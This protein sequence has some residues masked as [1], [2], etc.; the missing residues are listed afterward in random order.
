MIAVWTNHL[1]VDNRIIDSAHK[2]I[3]NV[4][5]RAGRLI[6]SRDVDA[7]TETFGALEDSLRAYFEIEERIAQAVNVDFDQHKVVHQRLL[8]DFHCMRDI[9]TE[10]NG[11][12][13]DSEAATL[14]DPWI[15]CFI[16]HIKDDEKHMKVVLSGQ[17]Y[18]FQPD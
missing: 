11:R 12:W 16:R 8:S 4:I 14:I 17:Y 5:N 13:S 7:L 9:L 18:D 15:K 2:N 3:L 1:S 6:G 10:K